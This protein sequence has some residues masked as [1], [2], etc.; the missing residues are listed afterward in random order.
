M[1]RQNQVIQGFGTSVA[2]TGMIIDFNGVIPIGVSS[3][4]KSGFAGFFVCFSM[5]GAK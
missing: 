3:I 5:P 1:N 2:V 4:A